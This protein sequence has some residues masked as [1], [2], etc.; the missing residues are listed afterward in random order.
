MKKII[1]L[2][3]VLAML[4]AMAPAVFATADGSYENPYVYTDLSEIPAAWD[5]DAA[6][7][8]WIQAPAY[9]A[10]ATLLNADECAGISV[11]HPMMGMPMVIADSYG[12]GSATV[13]LDSS[14]APFSGEA[15]DPVI[16]GITNQNPYVATSVGLTVA[17]SSAGGGQGGGTGAGTGFQD[18]PYV[19]DSLD[20]GYLLTAGT[21]WNDSDVYSKYN[22]TEAGTIEVDAAS[23]VWFSVNAPDGFDWST[24]GESSVDVAVGD[25]L[26]INISNTTPT[27]FT[28]TVAYASSGSQGGGEGGGSGSQGGNNGPITGTASAEEDSK[29]VYSYTATENGTLTITVGNGTAWVSDVMDY[30]SFGIIASASDTN[31]GSYTCNVVA[32]GSYGIRIYGAGDPCAAI[33]NIPYTITFTPSGTSAGPQLEDYKVSDTQLTTEGTHDVTVAVNEAEVTLYNFEPGA[34]GQFKIELVSGDVAMALWSNNSYTKI[35]DA[36]NGVLT[37]NITDPNQSYFIALAGEGAAAQLKVTRT[38]EAES[39]NSYPTTNYVNKDKP[40]KFEATADDVTG[41]VDI[42]D[43]KVDTAVLGKDGYYHLNSADGEILYVDFN[44]E[45][46]N[47]TQAWSNGSTSYAE[48]DGGKIVSVIKY[49]DALAEYLMAQNN[50]GT[51]T[52]GNTYHPLTAD[53]MEMLKNIG[54]NNGWYGENGMV[55]KTADAWMFA[56]VTMTAKTTDKNPGNAQTG[57]FGVIAAAVAMAVST[58]GGT[59]VVVKKKEN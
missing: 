8:I 47:L 37:V 15:G 53:L 49:Q 43:S 58:I 45:I 19:I 39:G 17:A 23:G 46:M 6:Q 21:N 50:G 31:E 30:S 36:E 20:G 26:Y 35:E 48:Y 28:A 29:Y 52:Y 12:T 3:V 2:L 33:S 18:D 38:G 10:T 59:A 54:E 7:T 9:G 32:G 16:F 24:N 11:M 27:T 41:K 34:T 51:Y 44:S 14:N 42:T 1:S 40:V 55:G 25:V 57:D 4:M 56:C 5:L 13:V 22:V